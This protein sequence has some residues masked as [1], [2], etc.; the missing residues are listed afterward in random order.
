MGLL[1]GDDVRRFIASPVTYQNLNVSASI[2]DFY[3]A[4]NL[5][6][7][8]ILM[9]FLKVLFVGCILYLTSILHVLYSTKWMLN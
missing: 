7:S 6:H 2:V 5:K 1:V 3:I 4:D 9:L 8:M